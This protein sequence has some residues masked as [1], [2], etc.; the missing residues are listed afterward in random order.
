MVMTN[1][2]NIP[3]IDGQSTTTFVKIPDGSWVTERI[4]DATDIRTIAEQA[5]SIGLRRNL[6]KGFPKNWNIENDEHNQNTVLLK[7]ILHLHSEVDEL[8][9][10]YTREKTIENVKEEGIDILMVTLGILAMTGV[11][12]EEEDLLRAFNKNEERIKNK[13]KI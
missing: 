11:T 3:E 9:K 1:L 4:L 8:Y 2:T 10:A 6:W 5:K 12:I 7:N 13:N